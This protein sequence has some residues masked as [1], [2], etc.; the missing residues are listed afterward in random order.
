MRMASKS[1]LNVTL[2]IFTVE[3]LDSWGVV[4]SGARDGLGEQILTN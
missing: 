3:K 4:R 2:E 1:L